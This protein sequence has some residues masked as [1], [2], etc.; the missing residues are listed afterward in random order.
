VT[1]ADQTRLV[2]SDEL[3]ERIGSRAATYDRE[4]RFFSEDFEELRAVG[5][6]RMPIPRAF[7]GLGMNLAEVC[8]EQARLA[9]Y[10]PATALAT[11]MHLYWMGVAATLHA[12]GDTSCDWMLEDGA[13]GEVFAAGH[14]ES[15]NDLPVLFSTTRAERVDGGYRFTGRKNFG[16]LTP[17]WTRLGLHGQDSS[18]PADPKVVHAFMSRDTPGYRIVETWD[19]LGMRATASQDTILEGAVVP[20][21]R[22]ARVVPVDF[23]GADLF[24]LALFVWVEP[25]FGTIY[26]AIARRAFDLAIAS[27]HEKRSIALG[28]KPMATNPMVQYTVAEM[29][30]ELDAAEAHLER[31]TVDWSTG[32]DHGGLWPAKLV[33]A[34]YHAVE[35]AR[36][37]TKLALDVAGGGAIFKGQEL[38]RL[39]RDATLGPVHP[40]NS[41]LV[42]E[43]V[44]KT[45]LGL[46]GQ[47]PRWG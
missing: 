35:A 47:S 13:S 28:G 25:T 26:T 38:E 44:G 2:L 15:G 32:V 24:V 22:V 9:Y 45:Y 1:T 27:A 41:L 5:Y 37:V 10:A 23:A 43:V 21:R 17:V 18:D 16:S 8:R 19:T 46:L 4:N 42:H 34:K 12:M 20:D 36:R 3:L 7:G 14:S 11:N 6:L 30:L 31:V 29:A 33:S 39:L 40:A